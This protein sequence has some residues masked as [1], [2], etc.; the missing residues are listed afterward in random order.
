MW[1][2]PNQTVAMNYE[3]FSLSLSFSS[4]PDITRAA[5]C[6][7]LMMRSSPEPEKWASDPLPNW[8][9]LKWDTINILVCGL[10]SWRQFARNSLKIVWVL[11]ILRHVTDKKYDDDDIKKIDMLQ[12]KY[13]GFSRGS[14]HCSE[15][16]SI[17]LILMHGQRYQS[18]FIITDCIM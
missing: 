12:E 8:I 9:Y 10:G 14:C 15:F 17:S 4:L 5:S 11:C 16:S 18:L 3:I 6:I 1:L 2:R 7:D 13:N